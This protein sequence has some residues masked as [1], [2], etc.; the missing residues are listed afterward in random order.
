MRERSKVDASIILSTQMAGPERP[1][2]YRQLSTRP[3][4]P[5]HVQYT[6]ISLADTVRYFAARRVSPIKAFCGGYFLPVTGAARVLWKPPFRF[7]VNVF[8]HLSMGL[9]RLL[10]FSSECLRCVSHITALVMVCIA[11]DTEVI[12]SD[13][14]LGFGHATRVSAFA[15]HILSL[16]E[17]HT[18]HIVSSAPKRVFATS[19]TL[20]AIY[21][22]AEID[23]IILQPLAFVASRRICRFILMSLSCLQIPSRPTKEHLRP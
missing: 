18:V 10:P 5:G 16:D 3:V 23:P 9:Y 19:I 1:P 8:I 14:Y 20:G 4:D 2:D 6:L 12:C 13:V 11:F 21:R 15:R 22:N 17:S 7:Y